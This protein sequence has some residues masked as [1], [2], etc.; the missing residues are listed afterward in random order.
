MWLDPEG[1]RAMDAGFCGVVAA[2]RMRV[3]C[4]VREFYVRITKTRMMI[5]N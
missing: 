5:Y 4:S 3:I 2:C 1:R